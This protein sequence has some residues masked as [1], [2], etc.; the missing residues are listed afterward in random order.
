MINTVKSKKRRHLLV[1][2]YPVAY[3]ERAHVVPIGS[4]KALTGGSNDSVR[5]VFPLDYKYER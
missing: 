2:T 1:Y 3:G 5:K 4:W